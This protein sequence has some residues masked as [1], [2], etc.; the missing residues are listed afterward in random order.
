MKIQAQ[1]PLGPQGP[2]SQSLHQGALATSPHSQGTCART[3]PM[4]G[5]SPSSPHTHYQHDL[6]DNHSPS[7]PTWIPVLHQALRSGSNLFHQY[8]WLLGP[9]PTPK[10]SLPQSHLYLRPSARRTTHCTPLH[11]VGL[12][13][14][15]T[16][17]I[18]ESSTTLQ[19]KV[20]HLCC[21]WASPFPLGASVSSSESQ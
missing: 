17:P 18:A 7:L 12:G 13:G 8:D 15:H 19:W 5:Q 16:G 2:C 20:V 4:E 6:P 10:H 11:P 21:P 1:S 9:W 3:S 14:L